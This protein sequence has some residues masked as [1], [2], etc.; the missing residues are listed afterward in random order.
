MKKVLV[1]TGPTA[2]GKTMVSISLAQKLNGE[3]INA[4]SMQIYKGCN[5]GSAKPSFNDRQGI[6][7]HLI[8]IIEPSGSFSTAEYKTFATEC[9]KMIVGKGKEPVITGGTGLYI[10][11]LIRNIEFN[12]KEHNELI[13]FSLNE[14]L[15]LN[16]PVFLHERLRKR[17]PEAAEKVHP[18]NTR[19]VIRYLEILDEYKGSLRD[20]M[21]DTVSQPPEFDFKIFVLW[22]SRE[23]IY[24][25]IETRIDEMIKDGLINEVRELIKSGVKENDQCM[26]GIGYK[27]TLAYINN[28]LN[29]ADYVE[30]FKMNTRR[31]AKRQFT[32][33]KR[34][35]N[36]EF[37]PIDENTDMISVSEKINSLYKN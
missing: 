25:R 14:L 27:E 30:L 26:M 28:Q 5:I 22:P 23:F 15:K 18:N 20:Y 21:A 31:Y 17:D 24:K 35:K 11:S 10:D 8:D 19:R 2:S 3:I 4:D 9:I 32:W 7:H 34:Y 12:E 33:F 29:Y 36:A 6:I 16:G 1:L 13:R 37:I